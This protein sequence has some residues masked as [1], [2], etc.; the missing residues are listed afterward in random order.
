VLSGVRPGVYEGNIAD[1]AID[2]T[3]AEQGSVLKEFRPRRT[4]PTDWIPAQ[5]GDLLKEIDTPALIVDLDK[6]E[7]NIAKLM[8]AVAGRCACVR[9]PKRTNARKLPAAR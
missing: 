2:W 9:M 8:A 4:V 7:A 1:M 5:P 6:C 3:A